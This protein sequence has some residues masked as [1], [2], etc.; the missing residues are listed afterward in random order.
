MSGSK[1]SDTL[2]VTDDGCEWVTYYPRDL[3]SLTIV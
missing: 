1:H 3:E 2:A